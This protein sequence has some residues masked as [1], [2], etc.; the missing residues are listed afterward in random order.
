M[1]GIWLC[2]IVGGLLMLRGEE[3]KREDGGR[4]KGD[5]DD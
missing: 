3:R 2:C 4:E 5:L 1:R